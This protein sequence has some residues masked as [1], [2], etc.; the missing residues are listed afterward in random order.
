[1]ADPQHPG[2]HYR[3]Q[4]DDDPKAIKFHPKAQPEKVHHNRLSW[5]PIVLNA[6]VILALAG[7]IIFISQQQQLN[8]TLVAEAELDAKISASVSDQLTDRKL[9]V[10]WYD[11]TAGEFKYETVK[12]E[13]AL[14]GRLD[15]EDYTV[16]LVDDGSSIYL[17]AEGL[18]WYANDHETVLVSVAD[19]Y[20]VSE[21]W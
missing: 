5:I 10:S 20:S 6:L 13:T 19:Q 2:S 1:M 18:T 7:F 3:N 14:T 8:Q 17:R 12:I 21:Q 16:Y 11:A 9:Y 4:S 15:G